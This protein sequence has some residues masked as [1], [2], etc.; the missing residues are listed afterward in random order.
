M[1][2]ENEYAEVMLVIGDILLSGA[3]LSPIIILGYQCFLYLRT[4][5]WES[6]S[7]IDFMIKFNYSWAINPTSW[8]G[9]HNILDYINISIPLFFILFFFGIGIRSE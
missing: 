5:V 3:F 9:L 1:A 7:I 6:L 2:S 8:M 4:G